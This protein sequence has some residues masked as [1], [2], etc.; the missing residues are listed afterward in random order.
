MRTLIVGAGAT[1]GYFGSRLARA[2][3]DVTFLVHPHRADQLRGGLR[4][5]GPGYDEI[6]PVRTTTAEELDRTYDLVLLMVKAW[7]LAAAMEDIAPAVGPE[8]SVLPLLNGMAHLDALNGRFGRDAVLGGIVRVVVTVAPDG[9]VFQ[10]KPHASLTLGSQD[11][12]QTERIARI[13][14][15][16][17]AP[18]FRAS[19]AGD[20]LAS[21]WHKWAF[22][23]AG[24]VITCLMRGTVGNVMAVPGGK[25]F[26][27]D[28]IEET[29][30]VAKA[31]GYAASA[32]AHAA[33]LEM[34]TEEGS[35]FTSSLYRDVVADAP[36][37]G[38]HLLGEYV[39]V[40]ER[41]GVEVPLTRLALAQLRV[42][43][44]ARLL[45]PRKQGAV[46]SGTG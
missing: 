23:T 36:H 1:G 45:D 39:A 12:R 28:V 42:H 13:G 5:H 44:Q 11:R 46:R 27:L 9:S 35:V 24:G 6:V 40:A 25:D 34:F 37:E 19:I 21:M 3:R 43:D 14:R 4:V 15:E 33:S 29:E 8:T 32:A 31:A 7:S 41:L 20:I 22:I 2:G 26:A 38:E 10:M 18:G 17:D 16:V 30:R